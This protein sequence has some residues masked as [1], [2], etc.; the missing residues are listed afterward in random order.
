MISTSA[1]AGTGSLVDPATFPLQSA[2]LDAGLIEGS[3]TTVSAMGADVLEHAQEADVAWSG[4][5]APGVFETPDQAAIQTLLTPAIDEATALDDATRRLSAALNDYASELAA[6]RPRLAD[7]EERAAEFRAEALQGYVVTNLTASGTGAFE[8]YW[9]ADPAARAQLAGTSRDP[10][11]LTTVPW[12][13]HPPAVHRNDSLL[14]EYVGIESQVET[15][16]STCTTSIRAELTVST[17]AVGALVMPDWVQPT[18]EWLDEQLVVTPPEQLPRGW[19]WGVWGGTHFL[20]AAGWA[21]S[22][23]EH[24]LTRPA[25]RVGWLPK[26]LGNA[27]KLFPI[28]QRPITAIT[29]FNAWGAKNWGQ[30]ASR[31]SMPTSFVGQFFVNMGQ[32]RVPRPFAAGAAGA[33]GVA[34]KVLGPLGGVVSGA[35][36]A[37]DQWQNDADNEELGDVERVTRTAVVGGTVAAGA[38]GGAM[39]GAAIG[40]AVPGVGTVVGGLIGGVIGGVAGS[41]L[42]A[43]VGDV[44]KEPFG[45]AAQWVADAAGDIGES[46]GDFVGGLFG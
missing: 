15:A 11:A 25:P 41:S 26:W 30:F 37:Y 4:L 19:D 31:A 5:Q 29:G 36:A 12:H 1:S 33:W 8:E 17:P 32:N 40:S 13:D 16:A 7:L 46:I 24:R 27:G 34:G 22:F 38:I 6:I 23:A 44:L 9:S 2:G 28:L 42:G 45:K 39:L 35:V 18:L 3:A 10:Y 14:A 21:V 43:A 20:T